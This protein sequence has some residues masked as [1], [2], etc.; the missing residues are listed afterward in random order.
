MKDCKKLNVVLVSVIL[1]FALA[2]AV[3]SFLLFSKR[4]ALSASSKKLAGAIHEISG[5]LDAN[6]GTA[7]AAQVTPESLSA[8]A[9]QAAVDAA[10]TKVKTQSRKIA[11]QRNDLASALHEIG[12]NSSA[13]TGSAADFKNVTKYPQQVTKTKQAVAKLKKDKDEAV[14][15][16][17]RAESA[18]A[19][20][21]NAEN[22]AVR[23]K[24]AAVA[25]Q[26]RAEEERNRANAANV[27]LKGQLAGMKKLELK[28]KDYE[29]RLGI[30]GA[31]LIAGSPEVLQRL[32]GKVTKVSEDYGYIAINLGAKSYYT[33]KIGNKDYNVKYNLDSNTKLLIVRGDKLIA[34]VQLDKVG[35]FESIAPIPVEKIGAIQTGDS[36]IWKSSK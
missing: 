18:A 17:N 28:V 8:S 34:E 31:T 3:L 9:D 2:S 26:R 19:R 11:Q 10:L 12:R 7:T 6:S 30:S 35:D 22:A 4:E 25:A 15:A 13:G 29:E 14:R 1:V 36:V 16:K 24:N 32:T 21:K 23:A 27:Q 33:Q 20:A 5:A